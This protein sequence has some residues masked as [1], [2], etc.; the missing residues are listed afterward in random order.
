MTN[1]M[2][3]KMDVNRY[4]FI[5]RLIDKTKIDFFQIILTY[6]FAISLL[7]LFQKKALIS[8]DNTKTL[9]RHKQ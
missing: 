4:F 2:Q 3:T 1:E 6:C 5:L 9:F 7:P 8:R